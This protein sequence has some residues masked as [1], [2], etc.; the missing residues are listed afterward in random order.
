MARYIVFD[1]ETPN[2][3]NSR[4]S[5]IGI[6]VIENGKII[7]DYYSLVNPETTFAD[8]NIRLTGITPEAAGKAPTFPEIWREIEPLMS[9]GTLVADGG[10]SLSLHGADGPKAASGHEP[11]P[12]RAV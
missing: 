9:S 11:P 4:M 5:A 3:K 1:V 10:S 6:S 2:E 12:E 8:F 7:R